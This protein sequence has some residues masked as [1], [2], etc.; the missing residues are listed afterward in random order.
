MSPTTTTL[1]LHMTAQEL[2]GE[3]IRLA[4]GVAWKHCRRL[5]RSRQRERDELD[6][7]V[8]DAVC[9]GLDQFIKRCS[10]RGMPDS[11]QADKWVAQAVFFA[12]KTTC[13]TERRLGSEIPTAGYVDAMN[14]DQ[15]GDWDD[16]MQRLPS[17]YGPSEG[18]MRRFLQHE[19][20]P[21]P[22]FLTALN[23]CMGDTKHESAVRQRVSTRTVYDSY[24][25]LREIYAT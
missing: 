14:R 5:L 25:K 24:R 8:Q 19:G 6:E 12:C 21:K 7:L 9:R 20:L 13:S 4:Y 15:D 22:L 2:F 18:Q 1:E 11:Q 3:R 17:W 10:K 23:A 16:H